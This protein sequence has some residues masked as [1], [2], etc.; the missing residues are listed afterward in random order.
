[1]PEKKRIL[2]VDD[3]THLLSGL[4]RMLRSM[5]DE[6][7]MAFVE[8]GPEALEALETIPFDVIVSDMRMPGMDGAELLNIVKDRYPHMSRIVLSGQ[9]S[10]DALLRSVGPTHQFLS[11]PC[12]AQIL[13]GTINRICSL[14]EVLASE[15]T[16]PLVSRIDTLPSL[17]ANYTQL[18]Q[19]LNNPEASLKTI[20]E[21]IGE[22]IAM[23]TKILQLVNSA[24]FGIARKIG[25]IEQAVVLLGLE[26]ISSLVLSAQVFS[27]F[28]LK[29]AGSFSL[30]ALTEHSYTVGKLAK[31]IA[32]LEEAPEKV[33]QSTLLAGMLHDTGKLILAS[34]LPDEY[35]KIVSLA[36]AECLTQH[37]AEQAILGVSHAQIGG[38]L[39]GLWGFSDEVTDATVFHHHP[40][41][42][43]NLAFSLLTVVHVA[44][45]FA[46]ELIQTEI[47]SQICEIS[48]EHLEAIGLLDRLAFWQDEC[49]EKST[50]K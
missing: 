45:V 23:T 9:S 4:R 41:D 18:M 14:R 30:Q 49:L 22:D 39:L 15:K 27:Q 33:R 43:P 7:E 32:I 6:W 20:G 36:R 10:K 31:Q 28:D 1:M 35:E 19:V 38:Y 11:K 50:V 34:E 44:D 42:N 47:P 29:K 26:T 48:T 37:E 2:F 21:I 46:H 13:T 25:D 24:F 12:D 3:E 40:L 16:Q 5:R 17:P 8:S